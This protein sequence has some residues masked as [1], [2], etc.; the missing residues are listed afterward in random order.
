[1]YVRTHAQTHLNP[2]SG[3]AHS[4]VTLEVTEE[5][6]LV[7]GKGSKKKWIIGGIIAIIVVVAIGLGIG[8]TVGGG[9][10]DSSE[11][12][13]GATTAPDASAPA[14]VPTEP[15]QS[16]SDVLTPCGARVLT[17]SYWCHQVECLLG[18]VL[19]DAIESNAD[20][21]VARS[22][23][24]IPNHAST[25]T[26]TRAHTQTNPFTHTRTRPPHTQP[27]PPRTRSS[28]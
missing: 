24:S 8:L 19:W 4:Q 1:M 23:S 14:P 5:T 3:G 25:H 10:S 21:N 28:P 27:A 9:S 22:L 13:S 12:D 6:Q 26:R 11:A 18:S 15:A 2:G 7:T 16:M 17:R 20:C